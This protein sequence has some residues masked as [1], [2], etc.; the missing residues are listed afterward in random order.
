MP[1][2]PR[3]PALLLGATLFAAS[4]APSQSVDVVTA[5]NAFGF[6]LLN[7]VQKIT[8]GKNVVLSPVSAALNLSMVLNGADGQT[9]QEVL[10]TLSLPAS[11][12]EAINAA[13]A[14]LIHLMRTPMSGITLSVADSL[15]ADSHR[16]TLSP[17]FVQQLNASYDAETA[18]L[19]FSLRGA[20]DQI[21]GW[22]SKQTQGKIPKV[23]DRIAPSD[24][25]LLLNAVYF[26]GVWG[27]KFDPARTQSRDFN[28]ITGATIQVPRMAQSG[29]VEYFETPQMQGIRLPFGAGD[30]VMQILLP[31]KSSGLSALED[32]LT[33]EHW[34]NWQAQYSM[35]PG[36]I[37]LPRFELRSD[38]KLNRALQALGMKRAFESDAQLAGMLSP[39]GGKAARVSIS[40]VMQ[41]TYWKVDE[42]GSEAAAVTTTGVRPTAVARPPQPFQMIIDRPFFCTIQQRSG[43][44]LFIGA[45]YDPRT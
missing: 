11:D 26:K 19:D 44:L 18:D 36:S 30:L 21:N 37:E 32:E 23:L 6:R 40:S 31:A 8:P 14:Q 42:E 5:D 17:A 25:L 15:W 7:A 13:N 35:H 20:A 3:L 39:A 24:V 10:D 41:S 27:Q 28:L 45:I 29:R 38:Y 9:R 1:L 2:I 43:A 16:A 33:P 22:A 4:I 34:K 12:L